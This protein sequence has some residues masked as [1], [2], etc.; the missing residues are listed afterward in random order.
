MQVFFA[1]SF[2]RE[3]F[4]CCACWVFVGITLFSGLLKKFGT[5]RSKFVN[6]VHILCVLEE[7]SGVLVAETVGVLLGITLFPGHLIKFLTLHSNFVIG[8][9]LL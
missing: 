3:D 4:G 9:N 7:F 8:Y 1:I 2:K 6:W 5:V